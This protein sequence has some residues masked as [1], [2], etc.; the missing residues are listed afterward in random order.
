MV[1][2]L[3]EPEVQRRL[4]A[5]ILELDRTKAIAHSR[6][7]DRR[8]GRPPG[9]LIH[10]LVGFMDIAI[11]AAQVAGVGDMHPGRECRR[12]RADRLRPVARRL[13]QA[14]FD[15]LPGGGADIR[16]GD[17]GEL[18][19]RLQWARR[20]ERV[21]NMLRGLVED[22]DAQAAERVEDQLVMIGQWGAIQIGGHLPD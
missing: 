19:A 22:S 16:M 5:G 6:P 12:L 9:R 20:A 3:D 1:Q 14:E 15:Q 2:F 17:A 21:E 13:K 11:G 4:A 10:G 8:D 7:K 18:D